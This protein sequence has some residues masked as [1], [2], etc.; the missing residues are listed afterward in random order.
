MTDR[1][2]I[3]AIAARISAGQAVDWAQALDR[4]GAG[5]EAAMLR[6]LRVLEAL[7]RTLGDQADQQDSVQLVRHLD[8]TFDSWL[9]SARGMPTTPESM[10]R[11]WGPLRILDQSG[12][13]SFA[14]IYRAFDPRLQR[15]VALK[16]FRDPD[17][18]QQQGLLQE[19][20]RLA[21]VEHPNV[22]RVYG[23]DEHDGR[24]GVWMEFVE[25]QTLDQLVGPS[26]Q[27]SAAEA[28][29]IGGAL[30]SA[31][32]AVHRAGVLHRDIKAHNVIRA[33]DG[34]IVLTD[35]GS[36]VDL[37]GSS[38]PDR[39][40][41]TPLYLAP[42]LLEQGAP[43]LQSDIYSLGVLLFHLLTGTYPVQAATIG[44]LRAAHASGR[45]LSLRD[46]RPELDQALVSAIERAIEA[47]P[48][49]RFGSM[50]EFDQA[51]ATAAGAKRGRFAGRLA[52]VAAV[53]G[54]LFL[55][56]AG[57][58]EWLPDQGRGAGAENSAAYRLDPTLY[59]IDGG[60]REPL[61]DGA[62][63]AVGDL[64]ALSLTADVDLY[65]Y[66]FNEDLR[67]HA[68]GLFPLP[69]LGQQNPLTAGAVHVLPGTAGQGEL[70]WQ[71][72]SEGGIERVHIVASPAPLP[73]FEVLFGRLP[74]A[75]LANPLLRQRGIGS[76]RELE[77]APALTAARL[78]GTARAAAGTGEL[79][80]G[81]WHRVIELS[82]PDG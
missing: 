6:N 51:L 49:N 33:V 36:G 71:V 82:H 13:G 1:S 61:A 66:V 18:T 22:V 43:S 77:S 24:V 50:G 41:G 10:P 34:R 19:G 29:I 39:L 25:G 45:R 46:A 76:V 60:G 37:P 12:S 32:A 14:E 73:E 55:S 38:D 20:R 40:V 30:C 28:S 5:P 48:E 35:F 11:S 58:R 16:L 2:G 42:E 81:A 57:L 27:F 31:V 59:R 26:R 65:V 54:I 9:Q 78:V 62:S 8:Q 64:L 70:A 23:A 15:E 79:A 3:E 52:L 21:R 56:W 53:L 74:A 47:R 44:E 69:G 4:A 63:V 80:T 7:N 75:T 68:F 72:D 67:G 17:P